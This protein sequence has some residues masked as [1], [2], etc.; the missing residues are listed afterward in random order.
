[1]EHDTH[2]FFTRCHWLY[3]QGVRRALRERLSAIYGA[4]WWSRGV[5]PALP[6]AVVQRLENEAARISGPEPGQELH[7]LLDASH[8]GRIVAQHH[9]T[10]FDDA[11]SDSQRTFRD[12]G[13]LMTARNRW[14]HL[15]PIS[16]AQAGQAAD[17]MRQILTALR[18]AEALEIA[19]MMQNIADQPGAATAELLPP[20]LE[21]TDAD[22]E[23]ADPASALQQLWQQAHSYLTLEKAVVLS[24]LIVG[25]QRRQELAQVNIRIHNTAPDSKDWPCVHFTSVELQIP[26]VRLIDGHNSHHLPI[27]L[28]ELAPGQM[29]EI[30][31]AFPAKQLLIAEF[32]VSGAVDVGKLFQ[33]QQTAYLPDEVI[34]AVQA[35]FADRWASIAVNDAVKDVLDAIATITPEMKLADV[36]QVRQSLANLSAGVDAKRNQLDLI[37]REF[38][39]GGDSFLGQ[40]VRE[41]ARALVDFNSKVSELDAAIGNTDLALISQ[42]V[43][44]LQQ[45]QL[46]VL[47][48]EDAI[49]GVTDNG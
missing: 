24:S 46:S 31:L 47:R 42:A 39:L 2:L 18:C 49:R 16:P 13:R 45:I 17:L 48:V 26:G 14:A 7:T 41:I 28:G 44:D 22:L 37:Y 43:R 4:D 12:F 23:R 32:V 40:R 27:R 21:P 30:E 36:V 25:R 38:H 20:E 9:R 19:D 10:A 35:E 15:Q 11:F 1:M 5:L 6:E 34:S 33:F 8:F 29:H 3:V